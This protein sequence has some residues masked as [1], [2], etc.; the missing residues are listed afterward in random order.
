[1]A[2]PT[3][4]DAD[5]IV[6]GAGLAGLTAA[7][8]LSE[9]GHRVLVVE[10][11]DEPGGRVRSVEWEDCSIE[12][13]AIFLAGQ[14]RRLRRLLDE[15]GMAHRLDPLPNAFRIAIRRDGHWHHTD[16]SRPELEIPRYRGLNRREKRSLLRLLPP[17]LRVALSL[18]FFDMATTAAVDDRSLTDV[19]GREANRYLIGALTEVF[20]GASAD[21]I[22]LGFGVL[23]ARYPLRRAWLLRGGMGS[24]T[25]EL[26]GR[27]SASCGIEVERL[28]VEPGGVVATTHG[29]DSLRARAAVLATRAGEAAEIWPAAPDPVRRFLTTQPYTQG[30]GVFL[31]TPERLERLDPRGRGVLMDILPSSGGH[32]ALLAAV[33]FNDLAPS[34]GLV[35]LAATPAASRSA[36]GDDE[37]AA[38]LESEFLR[39]HPEP[40][41]DVTARLPLRWPVFVP[42]YPVGRARELASLRSRLVPG[43]VQLAGDYLYGPLMEGA[44]NAGEAAA[45]RAARYLRLGD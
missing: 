44:V 38:R 26:A 31:R 7:H 14:Y 34:G 42:W 25:H 3:A 22:P 18:R 37:L 12:L 24:L 41:P 4:H 35:G 21:E 43:P 33:Y 8:R 2:L 45:D 30:F 13:G 11:D 5:V 36:T 17:Q 40:A 27:L 15:L 39:L 1:M 9:R 19:V 20:C 23:G 32:G 6:V 16:F 10:R 28:Q 29:G